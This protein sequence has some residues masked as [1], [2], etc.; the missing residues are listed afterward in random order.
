VS[1]PRLASPGA[2]AL[3][4]TVALAAGCPA[5]PD[6]AQWVVR[7]GDPAPGAGAPPAEGAPPTPAGTAVEGGPPPAEGGTAPT[8]RSGPP[9]GAPGQAPPEQTITRPVAAFDPTISTVTISGTI[10]PVDA[11]DG[12]LRLDVMRRSTSALPELLHS[13]VL[14]KAGTFAIK[15]PPGTGEVRL[16]AYW[17]TKNPGPQEG[18]TTGSVLVRVETADLKGLAIKI[19]KTDKPDDNAGGPKTKPPGPGE[20]LAP[21]DGPADGPAPAGAPADGA[22]PSPAPAGAGG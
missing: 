11:Q 12:V 21:V 8:P 3:L 18:E 13:E 6:D 1:A 10:E 15:A 9:E 7:E 16:V 19:A 20:A 14:P 17:D 22:A 4:L 2:L 5:P